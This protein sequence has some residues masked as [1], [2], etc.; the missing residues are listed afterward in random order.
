MNTFANAWKTNQ[1]KVRTENGAATFSTAGDPNVDL[2][3]QLP[4]MR[5][6]PVERV[7]NL[8]A[9]A[10]GE[11][12]DI[13]TRILLWT[14][15]IRGGQGERQIFRD[16]LLWIEKNDIEALRLILPKVPELGRWDDLLVLESSE[17]RSIARSMIVSA[18]QSG[19]GLCAKWM[20]RKGPIASALLISMGLTPKQYRKMIVGLTQVVEQ[21]MCAKE[22][23]SIEYQKV[24]SVAQSRYSK[25]FLKHDELR[26]R[27][28]GQKA[29]EYAEAVASGDKERI[30]SVEKVKINAGAVY[31]YD[32]LKNV[33]AKEANY[34]YYNSFGK[35]DDSFDPNIVRAQWATLPNYVGN[36]NI[37]PM[38]DVSGSM[39]S[40]I[41]STKL[42]AIDVAVS[43]GLYMASKNTGDFRNMML[44]F[45]SI[46][47][48]ITLR[49]DDVIGHVQQLLTDRWHGSTNI[50]AG[51]KKILEHAVYNNVRPEDMPEYIVVFS[52]M[53]FNQL[54]GGFTAYES[55]Q[56]LFATKGYR[57]PKI[58]W[59]NIQ[60]R[61]DNVPVRFDQNGTALVAGFSPSTAK[62]IMSGE[63]INPRQMMLSTI[64]DPRYDVLSTAA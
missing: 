50:E 29:K 63:S 4:A 11:D 54:S 9:K 61:H 64:M 59:W 22:W 56:N 47:E 49:G 38:V 58:V 6:A 46:P 24:P 45:T 13:A 19:N 25:A 28:F 52:D 40:S 42:R 26:Y 36:K 21:K 27:E 30:A 62:G 55:Y 60:S 51:F 34:P 3:F 14:R 1:P 32:V 44:T 57:A 7:H 39:E 33:V 15:D 12:R 35:I 31:P 5:G 16:I 18:L 17:G 53:E 43:L 20:P 48:L 8:F 2:F 37:L 23:D 41:G 10:F